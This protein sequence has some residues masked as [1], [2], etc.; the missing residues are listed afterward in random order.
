MFIAALFTIVKIW[1]HSVSINR[2][3]DKED[4]VCMYDGMSLSC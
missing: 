2:Q 3:M 4:M 1:K